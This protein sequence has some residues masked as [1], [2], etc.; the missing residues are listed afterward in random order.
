LI[1]LMQGIEARTSRTDIMAHSLACSRLSSDAG[2]C[3]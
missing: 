3:L 1:E 2:N